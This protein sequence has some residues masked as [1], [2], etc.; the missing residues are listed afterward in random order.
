MWRNAKGRTGTWI[1]A[2]RQLIGGINST[3][4][5]ALNGYTPL[6]VA[7]QP[8]LTQPLIAFKYGALK[9]PTLKQNDRL[10][11]GQPVRVRNFDRGSKKH[12]SRSTT[13]QFSKDVFYIF[14]ILERDPVIKYVLRDSE[15]HSLPSTWLRSQLKPLPW[16]KK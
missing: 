3:P 11:Q 5:K 13:P 4:S 15:G 16:P 2:L 6:Q 1:G 9:A 8:E 14:K 7:T 12:F 10:K